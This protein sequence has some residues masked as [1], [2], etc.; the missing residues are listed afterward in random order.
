MPLV[1]VHLSHKFSGGRIETD[2]MHSLAVF[3]QR[4][5]I[6]AQGPVAL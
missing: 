5:E 4:G 1:R 6:A 3:Q 2:T